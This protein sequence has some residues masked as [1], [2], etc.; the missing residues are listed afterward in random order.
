MADGFFFG[1]EKIQNNLNS[2]TAK[3]YGLTE[4][5]ICELEVLAGEM[6]SYAADM[7]KNE[8][9]LSEA[10]PLI[11]EEIR[12]EE[13]SL[14]EL[15]NNLPENESRL[16]Y[17]AHI[18]DVLDKAML[19]ELFCERSVNYGVSVSEAEILES[20]FGDDSFVYVKNAY[21]DE[22]YEVLTESVRGARVKYV[23][24]SREAAIAVSEGNATYCILPLEEHSVRIASVSELIAAYDLKINR[25]TSVFGFD[26]T[27]DMK[28]A[29]LS[30]S[31]AVPSREAGDDRYLEIRHSAKSHSALS[32]IIF[33]AAAYGHKIYRVNTAS[34]LEDG[35]ERLYYSLVLRDDERDFSA[36]LVY[37]SLFSPE[38]VVVGMYKN[39][40]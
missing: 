27:A 22:A 29:M 14:P 11:S 35:E 39:L 5:R 25:V 2:L 12:S 8:L 1:R 4:L 21:S 33:A 10:L 26:G 16:A 38:T 40:E 6:L 20:S 31:Y 30:H 32:D 3:Q 7:S 23:N 28:Y 18:T 37:L 19:S 9:R 13:F 17:A 36:M 34:A 24:S 15:E